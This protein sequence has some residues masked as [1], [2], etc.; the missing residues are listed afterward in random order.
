MNFDPDT[1]FM[2]GAALGAQFNEWA[3]GE[4]EVS[5]NWHGDGEGDAVF[6]TSGV[7]NYGKY[8]VDG[9]EHALFVLANCGS[10]CRSAG[11]F[12]PMSA[13]VLASGDFPWM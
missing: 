8:D 6:L 4:I 13:A 10:I 12:G 5:G 11:M 1:G 3:R 2:F 7:N 9:D